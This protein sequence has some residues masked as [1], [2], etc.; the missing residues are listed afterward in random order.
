MFSNFLSNFVRFVRWCR[1]IWQSETSHSWQMTVRST[2]FACWI[3]KATDKTH[4]VNVMRIAFPRQQW[5]S[6]GAS[7][8]RLYVYCPSIL[9]WLSGFPDK[10]HSNFTSVETTFVMH[11][12]RNRNRD[13][14]TV[15]PNKILCN[16]FIV[17]GFWR[18]TVSNAS[19]IAVYSLLYE[20]N[21]KKAVF[22]ARH[23]V[24]SYFQ[25]GPWHVRARP[26][27]LAV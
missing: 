1:K 26:S 10:L 5:G 22:K 20:V 13:I 23:F 9:P 15:R 24:Q 25:C 11:D 4:S 12:A 7:V 19:I 6:E 8:L 3:N 21:T 14:R 17:T 27:T 2:R 16:I 18:N